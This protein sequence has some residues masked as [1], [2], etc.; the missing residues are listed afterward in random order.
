MQLIKKTII[1]GIIFL[2]FSCEKDLYDEAIKSS[3]EI[4]LTRVSL[5]N[6]LVINNKNLMNEIQKIKNK[7]HSITNSSSKIIYDSINNFYFDD[8]NGIMIEDE[9][10]YKSFTFP[11]IRDV[12]SQKLENIVFSL[13]NNTVYETYLSKY[14]FTEFQKEKILANE[15]VDLSEVTPDIKILQRKNCDTKIDQCTA[16]YDTETGEYYFVV[17]YLDPCDTGGSTGTDSSSSDNGGSG[18]GSSGSGYIGPTGPTGIGAGAGPRGGSNPSGNGP[19]L[20]TPVFGG[21]LSNSLANP[22][23]KVKEQTNKYQN[24]KPSL[25]NLATTTT[26]SQENG[27]YVDDTATSTTANPINNLSSNA[28]GSLNIPY[29]PNPKKYSVL[30]HTHDASGSDGNGTFSIFSFGDLQKIAQ[31]I[32]LNQI[33]ESFVFFVSTADGTNYALTIDWPSKFAEYF[34]ERKDTTIPLSITNRDYE[35][36]GKLDIIEKKYY[37]NTP[38]VGKITRTSNPTDDKNL[39]LTMMKELKL[40]I[41][42]FEVTDNFNTFSKLQL[43][44]GIVT[45]TPCN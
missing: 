3:R 18:G 21:G 2:L 27:F 32:T 30:A 25:I 4:K 45:A 26:Q 28:G 6:S 42:I 12:P 34:D 15:F 41:S 13:K 11:I 20:T 44:K 37:S 19:I 10:G 16:Y 39:F 9:E 8:E 23:K 43:K 35:K 22:C 33:D 38:A 24:L 29:L 40:D 5:K 14:T 31:L 36:A 7:K 17:T 1:F